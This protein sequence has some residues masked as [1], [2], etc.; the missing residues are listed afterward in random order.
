MNKD[1]SSTRR[2]AAI[3]SA[4]GFPDPTRPYVPFPSDLGTV[5]APSFPRFP[6]L[7]QVLEHQS[8]QSPHP[9]LQ[10]TET[11]PPSRPTS[12]FQGLLGG[13]LEVLVQDAL[14]HPE[15][16]DAATREALADL[17]AGPRTLSPA[18]HRLLDSA[19]LDYASFRPPQPAPRATSAPKPP[20]RKPSLLDDGDMP[21]GREPQVETPGGP[22][23][24][25]WW[26]T[27]G[28]GGY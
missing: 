15:R 25:Y 16:Y 19:T 10:L 21:D 28:Q 13:R 12:L 1:G 20:P 8:G 17:G 27:G 26:V 18:D 14:D 6:T 22:M 3:K 23:S 24:A 4:L 2:F 9:L 5:E 7:D 11:T